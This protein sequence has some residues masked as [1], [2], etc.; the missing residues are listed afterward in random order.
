MYESLGAMSQAA[1]YNENNNNDNTS[2]NYNGLCLLST[3]Y[4]PALCHMLYVYYS[5][6]LWAIL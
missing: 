2:N 3:N 1:Y 6:N 5:F 4:L